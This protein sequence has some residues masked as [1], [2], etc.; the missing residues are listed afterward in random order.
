[1]PLNLTT[2]TA[3]TTTAT[4]TTAGYTFSAD[5]AIDGRS[6]VSVVSALSGTQTGVTV[7]TVDAPKQMIFKKP[8]T[9]QVP[10]AYNSVSGKYGKVPKNVHRVIF[11][12]AAKVRPTSGRRFQ[13]PWIYQSLLVRLRTIVRML[14]HLL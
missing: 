7:H 4:L 2:T 1:M 5:L 3:T 14:M 6:K 12:G 13:F 8:A 11:R 10:S 9:F